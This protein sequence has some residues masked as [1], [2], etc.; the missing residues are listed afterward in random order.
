M[1]NTY[2]PVPNAKKVTDMIHT[3][4]NLQRKRSEIPETSLC[5]DESEGTW[6]TALLLLIMHQ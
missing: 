4:A 6:P 2:S 5:N 3:Q 1:N